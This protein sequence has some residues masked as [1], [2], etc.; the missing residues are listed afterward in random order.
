MPYAVNFSGD[1]TM[2]NIGYLFR[3]YN[4]LEGNP[5]D[6]DR[7][8]D[9][10]FKSKIFKAT[11]TK[12]RRTD[13]Q[14]YKIPDFVDIFGKTSCSSTFSSE[15]VMTVSEYQQSLMAKAAVSG[16]A[17]YGV[18][19]GSFSASTEYNRMKSALESNT[20]SIIKTEATCTVYEGRIQ[21]GTP[22]EFTENF[23]ESVKFYSGSKEY[24]KLLDTFG[25][26]FVEAVEMG[27]RLVI[28]VN[29]FQTNPQSQSM[30]TL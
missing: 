19:K 16:S 7:S 28:G 30:E 25:T 21:T 6:P 12:D 5:I 15:T 1:S 17:Q 13:D 26:H 8:F 20:K 27:A 22:P 14:R 4:V 10:G 9:P 23:L 2:S 3:G 24:D 18:V 11:Y 29:I